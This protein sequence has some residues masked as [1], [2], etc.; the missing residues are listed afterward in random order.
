MDVT[1]TFL[2]QTERRASTFAP[3]PVPQLAILRAEDPPAHFYR[4]LYDLVGERYHWLTRKNLSDEALL[5]II[6]APETHIYVLYYKGAPA[7]FCEID[8]HDADAVCI[9]LFGLAPHAYGQGLGRYFF[10]QCVDLAWQT[11]PSRVVLETCTLDHPA[12]LPL[13]QKLGFTPYATR[14]GVVDLPEEA[15]QSPA[16]EPTP[17]DPSSM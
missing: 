17:A 2:E 8:K 15:L 12:A 13:Y 1:I 9:K 4:Y 14:R 3:P 10:S 7:G 11:G 6:A 16:N 5:E